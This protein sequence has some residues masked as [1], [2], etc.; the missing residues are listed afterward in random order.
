MKSRT[1]RVI[2]LLTM[3]ACAGIVITQVYWVRKAYALNEQRFDLD[4]NVALRNVVSTI[5]RDEGI[6]Q[7]R[8]SPVEETSPG[9]FAVPIN[10][11]IDKKVLAEGLAAAF[12]EQNIVTDFQY[13]LSSNDRNS[14]MAYTGTYHMVRSGAVAPASGRKVPTLNRGD[15]SITVCFPNRKRYLFSQLTIWAVSSIVLLL[16]VGFLCYLLWVIFKQRRLSEVQKD[17]VANMTHEFKTPLASIRLSA[18]VLKNP[19]ILKQPQR[20]L[21]YATIISNEAMQLTGH[22]ERVLQMSK[23]EREGLHLTRSEFVWQDMLRE[24]L[25]HYSNMA[26]SKNGIV[27]MQLPDKPVRFTGDILHLK[28][29]LNNL[30]DNAVKY[31]VARPEIQIILKNGD[32]RVSVSVR[33]NGMGIDKTQ[34]GML[35]DKFFRVHTGNVHDVKG[36]GIGLNYVRIIARAHGGEVTCNSQLGKGSTFTLILPLT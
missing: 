24:E 25:Q 30:V 26:I 31:C 8:N 6:Q 10:A 7:A 28:N 19:G 33:D 21:N 35:F 9:C 4:V 2:V 32:G 22:I 3:L 5:L 34:Q 23:A 17:F 27:S 12:A 36:F 16:V 20:L 18:D 11:W 13:G 15:Y 1:I 29:A 14:A